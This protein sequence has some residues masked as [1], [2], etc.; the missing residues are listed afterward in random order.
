MLATALVLSLQMLPDPATLQLRLPPDASV[1]DAQ[2]VAAS[3]A[4]S[5]RFGLQR[6][7][8]DAAAFLIPKLR[9]I[10]IPIPA[11]FF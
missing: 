4:R 7:Y 1:L 3:D 8:A 11:L 6:V 5:T 9:A 10:P 2:P